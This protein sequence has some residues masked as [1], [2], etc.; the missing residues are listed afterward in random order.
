MRLSDHLIQLIILLHLTV[1]G[2]IKPEIAE[3]AKRMLFLTSLATKLAREGVIKRNVL[4]T[5][6]NDLKL[7]KNDH[8]LLLGK[9]LSKSIWTRYKLNRSFKANKNDGWD[10][11]DDQ[12]R[13]FV[14][15]NSTSFL[16]LDDIRKISDGVISAAPNWIRYDV[17]RM[18]SD[19]TDL[20]M[21]H[22]VINGV[23]AG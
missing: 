11:I 14:H 23:T 7:A 10:G 3:R 5:L 17:D 16:T 4:D 22:P 18:Q 6:N 13:T 15:N 12:Y 9:E 2:F 8:C 19:V 21:T 1:L 20:F